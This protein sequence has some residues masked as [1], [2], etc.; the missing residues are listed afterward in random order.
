MLLY[1]YTCIHTH[2]W[3]PYIS[4]YKHKFVYVRVYVSECGEIS[5]NIIL[6]TFQGVMIIKW[7]S[8]VI[9]LKYDWDTIIELEP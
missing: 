5:L 8:F 9:E 3:L 2:V 7:D 6:S 1:K 4:I